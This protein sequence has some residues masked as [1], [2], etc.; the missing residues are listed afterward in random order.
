MEHVP[1]LL[2]TAAS[3]GVLDGKRA[4]QAH[5]IC[6]GVAA[7]DAL[8][9]GVGGPIFFQCG[10]LLLTTQLFNDILWHDNFLRGG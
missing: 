3:Q 9:T 4:A 6:C 1:E 7:L 2:C 5:D 8:P 10:N